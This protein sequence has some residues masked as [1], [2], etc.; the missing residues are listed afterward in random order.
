MDNVIKIALKNGYIDD[1]MQLHVD[2]FRKNNKYIYNILNQINDLSY[3]IANSSIANS[4]DLKGVYI[5]TKFHQIHLSYQ[6]F[7]ILY[8]RGLYEDSKVILRSLYDKIIDIMF[9]AKNNENIYQVLFNEIK[10]KESLC[11]YIEDNKL[12]KYLSKK[13]IKE[14]K[15]EFE[16]QINDLKDK[17]NESL[18]RYSFKNKCKDINNKEL[19]LHYRYNSIYTHNSIQV[20]ENR[21]I[22]NKKD[23]IIDN[24]LKFANI[25]DEIA[26][27]IGIY[28]YA[29]KTICEYLENNDYYNKFIL[30]ESDFCNLLNKNKKNTKK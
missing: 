4:N 19:Y 21:I 17:T 15:E 5:L 7:I 12:Y 9:V 26:F 20:Q 25:T 16:N 6:S 10:E 2:N 8:E 30:I 29:I 22:R 28:K 18:K 14:A 3:K 11:K 23:Y 13:K 27:L 24:N 1:K